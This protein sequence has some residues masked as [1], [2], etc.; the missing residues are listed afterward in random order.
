MTTETKLAIT[1][2]DPDILHI[3]AS[4]EK[5]QLKVTELLNYFREGCQVTMLIQVN[6]F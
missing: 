1:K 5:S 4:L 6:Q 3:C 2:L